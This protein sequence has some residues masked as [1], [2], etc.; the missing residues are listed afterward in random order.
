MQCQFLGHGS[1]ISLLLINDT[2]ASV[3]G[4]RPVD[5][6]KVSAGCVDRG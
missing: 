2:L 5:N 3:M 1:F 4:I 6:D